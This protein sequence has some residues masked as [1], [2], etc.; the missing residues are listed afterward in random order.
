MRKSDVAGMDV[1]RV[2]GRQEVVREGDR[3]HQESHDQKDAAHD[4]ACGLGDFGLRPFAHVD[5]E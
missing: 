3:D 5:T 4:H 1:R 2:W